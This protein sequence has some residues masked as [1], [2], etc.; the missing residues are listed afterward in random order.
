MSTSVYI[1]LGAY[2]QLPSISEIDYFRLDKILFN[3]FK[4]SLSLVDIN[5]GW[6]ARKDPGYFLIPNK[7][8][9][10]PT[11]LDIDIDKGVCVNYSLTPETMQI[12]LNNF[13]QVFAKELERLNKEFQYSIE[14][15]ILTYWW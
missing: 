8:Y 4:E 5:E 3:E 9:N 10:E 6:A 13:K 12:H 7:R 2:I 14:W 15:G 11:N 1:Y